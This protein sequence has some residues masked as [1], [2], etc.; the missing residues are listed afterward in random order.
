MKIYVLQYIKHVHAI[1]VAVLGINHLQ[2]IRFSASAPRPG[3]PPARRRRRGPFGQ[4]DF[5]NSARW[6]F[7]SAAC[8]D[9]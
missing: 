9:D 7:H 1:F 6:L 4:M 3:V 2:D 8:I 5:R